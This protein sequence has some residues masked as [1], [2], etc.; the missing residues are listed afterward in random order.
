M[1]KFTSIFVLTLTLIG[2][3]TAQTPTQ[4]MM[5]ERIPG[6]ESGKFAYPYYFFV[7]PELH[8]AEAANQTH[9]ILVLPNNTGKLSDDMAVHEADVKKRLAAVPT[10]ASLLKVAVLM[11]VFPRPES[12]WQIYTHALDRDSMV[13]TK[14]EYRRLDLQLVAMIDD[15]RTRMAKQRLKFDRRV[16]LNGYSASGMFVNRFTF[17]HPDRVKAAAIGSPGGWP[18]VPVKEYKEKALRYPIG[19]SKFHVVLGKKLNLR[20][21]RKV[22]L[23]IFMGDKDDNDSV[24]FGDSYDDED[25]DVI[26]PLFGKTPVARWD[27]ARSLYRQAGLNAEFKLYPGVAH[28]VTTAMRD[29]IRAF[30]QKYR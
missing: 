30:L 29:D 25:R 27:I 4:P 5:P 18:I 22:P 19:V 17:L 3:A 11:P 13:T 1:M 23:L 28:T 2:T 15:A 26:N 10:I 20:E 24:A 6:S 21:L 12:D 16:L 14:K 8:S 7:P 9:T